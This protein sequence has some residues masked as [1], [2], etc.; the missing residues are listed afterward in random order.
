M[1]KEIDY[2]NINWKNKFHADA[3]CTHIV[4]TNSWYHAINSI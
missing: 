2:N 3:N 4:N 1:Y